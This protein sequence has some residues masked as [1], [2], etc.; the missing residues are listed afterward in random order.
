M[1]S[2]VVEVML[3]FWLAASPFIFRHA[4]DAR[5]LWVNDLLCGFA[6]VTLGLLSFWQPLRQAHVATC[7]VAL[8]LIGFGCLVSPYPAPPALQNNILV[9]ALLLM[10]AIIPNESSVPPKAWRDLYSEEMESLKAGNPTPLK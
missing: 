2:R 9:G 3:G 1:W 7:G 8:W 4:P 6:V 5:A 10:F